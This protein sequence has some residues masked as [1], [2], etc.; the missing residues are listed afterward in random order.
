[1]ATNRSETA[2]EDKWN[3][4]AL[5]PSIADW[6]MEFSKFTSKEHEN[7]L[8]QISKYKGKLGEGPETLKQALEAIL[9]YERKLSTLFTYA[10]LRHDEEITVDENKAAYNVARMA[11]YE[12]QSTTAW[13][14]PELLSLPEETIQSY[15]TS[16]IL[17]DYQFYLKK[18]FAYKPHTLSADQEELMA[19]S[20]RA[21][22]A[23]HKAFSAINDA[24][25]VFDRVKDS[26]GKDL[27]LTHGKYAIYLRSH[28]RKL[29]ENA[30]KTYHGKYISF[31]NTLC[32][33]LEGQVQ[34]HLFQAK[35]RKFNSCLEAALFPNHIDPKVYFTLIDAVH[36]KIHSHHRYMNLRTKLLN[37]PKL[38]M[39]DLYVPL[40]A[41]FDMKLPYK[42]AEELVIESTAPLGKA[43]QDTLREGLQNQRWVDR[44]EN[45]NKRSG[46]YSSGCYDSM[47]YILMNYKDIIRDVFTLA[48]EV[49]HSM[50]SYLSHSN[51][52]YQYADYPIFLAEIAST[53]N[54]ELLMQALLQRAQSK[55][56]KIY[57]INQKIEDIRATLFRQTMFAEFELKIHEYAEKGI[58]L[59][60]KLLDEEYKRLNE[61]Y[62]GPSVECDPEI[63]I[64]WARIPHFYYNFYVF[65]YATGISAALALADKVKKGRDK[66]RE[67]YLSFL[68]SGSSLYPID[69]LLKAGI[70]MR[71][72]IPVL[73]AIDKFDHLVTELEE[74][75]R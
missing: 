3:V 11:I 12:L 18:I 35:A 42:E 63:E 14:Q 10:H 68:K 32:E 21:L 72:P 50:H 65:Q 73:S 29:R 48:H 67:D 66:E 43:Y 22:S 56:E 19:Q 39:Y 41:D 28:D 9:N 24:D 27:E 33:L 58:P 16:P 23:P 59:T 62:F 47:P 45:K 37:L 36:E 69:L 46:A 70:D 13:F 38:H 6:Q 75:T 31:K 71:T 4:E 61:F 57:L 60:P 55:E 20:L 64:E 52:P 54:E 74:L 26:E 30:F 49:G 15:L 2:I 1:M 51:Q 8:M 53:F 25:F 40:M 17:A 5:F 7:P 34:A 44:F